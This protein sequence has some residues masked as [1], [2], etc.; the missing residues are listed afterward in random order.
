MLNL[1]PLFNLNFWFAQHPVPITS[2]STRI[3]VVMFTLMLIAGSA[4]RIIS[5]KRYTDYYV[6]ETALKISKLCTTMGFLGLA[7]LFFALEQVTFL[8]AR[9]WM[10]VWLVGVIVWVISII[11]Y[12]RV[13][14]P[15]EREIHNQYKERS[16]YL[17][18]K[19][20]K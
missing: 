1:K 9:Y 10:M 13:T 3:T 11:K 4:I 12:A 19:K 14:V 6:K 15:R 20:R 16:K 18:R 2:S 5:K 8:Q 17:P 7:W